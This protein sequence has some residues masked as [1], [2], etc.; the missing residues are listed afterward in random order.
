MSAQVPHKK[1]FPWLESFGIFM[2]II[3]WNLLANGEI[4]FFNAALITI[5]CALI[6]F[7][8]RCRKSNQQ[9]QQQSEAFGT[10]EQKV[11][12]RH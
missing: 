2:G 8:L 3:A 5:P 12:G 11:T 1:Q 10:A 9:R 6:W 7:M 4:E